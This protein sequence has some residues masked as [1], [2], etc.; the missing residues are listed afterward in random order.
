MCGRR[1]NSEK[2]FCCRHK[3][4]KRYQYISCSVFTLSLFFRFSWPFDLIPG[5]GS[6]NL[7][8]STQREIICAIMFKFCLWISG[9]SQPSVMN[10]L[11]SQTFSTSQD[12]EHLQYSLILLIS[13]FHILKSK[14]LKQIIFYLQQCHLFHLKNL[15]IYIAF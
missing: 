4:F 5:I 13:T 11:P 3:L 1:R 6:H 9:Q 12:F 14:S 7:I 10:P 2:T 8:S 15:Y